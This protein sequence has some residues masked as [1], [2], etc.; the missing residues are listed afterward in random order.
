MKM[1]MKRLV[2]LSAAATALC[3]ASDAIAEPRDSVDRGTRMDTDAIRDDV[4]T[5]RLQIA[6]HPIAAEQ[7]RQPASSLKGKNKSGK[8]G[9]SNQ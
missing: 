5:N 3:A 2:V 4:R 6:E 1:I 7:P 9:G 8:S